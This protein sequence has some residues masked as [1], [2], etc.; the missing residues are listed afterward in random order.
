MSAKQ[1]ETRIAAIED[2]DAIRD[3]RIEA[4]GAEIDELK[5]QLGRTIVNKAQAIL[6]ARTIPMSPD[7]ASTGRSPN[8]E[9]FDAQEA[10]LRSRTGDRR[11]NTP[12]I[13]GYGR[14][15]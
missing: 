6:D 11:H 10:M 12:T 4:L 1:V 8:P 7:M 9:Q 3:E 2:G 13:P 5:Q 14:K 15:A